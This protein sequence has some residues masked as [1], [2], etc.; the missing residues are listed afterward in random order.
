LSTFI[1]LESWWK[2]EGVGVPVMAMLV[3]PSC[4]EVFK[5]LAIKKKFG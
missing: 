3:T 1:L 2:F 5:S 4:L